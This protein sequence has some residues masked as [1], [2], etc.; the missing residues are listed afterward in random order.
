[1]FDIFDTDKSGSLEPKELIE[2]FAN[3]DYKID[4]KVIY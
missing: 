4:P 2:A 3:S 1:M